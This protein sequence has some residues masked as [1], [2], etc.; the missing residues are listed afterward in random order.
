MKLKTVDYN[1]SSDDEGEE[2]MQNDNPA[3]EESDLG[4]EEEQ[5]EEDEGDMEDGE[6]QPDGEDQESES[7][8]DRH[9]YPTP[10]P[11]DGSKMAALKPMVAKPKA[12]LISLALMA[13]E[14][15]ASRS[16]SSVKAIMSYLK[17]NG[18]EWPDPKKTERLMF[19]ALK[20]AE[21]KEEVI[22]VKRSFK[23]SNKLKSS[24]K[25]VEKMKAKKLKDKEKEKEKKAKAEQLLK[26]KAEKKKAKKK[27]KAM[28]KKEAKEKPS[29]P[30]ERKTKQA[31]KKKKEDGAKDK[32]PASKTA[33]SA[34]VQAMLETPRTT[35][36]GAKI[37]PG[38][39]KVKSNADEE[40]SEAGKAKK[41]RKSIGTLAQ[42]KTARPK[43]KAV[44][45]L[46][47]GKALVLTPDPSSSDM[48]KPQAMS[49][50]QEPTK[51]KRTRKA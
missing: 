44:K 7:E 2:E 36:P 3:S 35:T 31:G 37:K 4:E 28:E 33:A 8:R 32:P 29:K 47:A 12:S 22:M 10:P 13:I 6:E 38:K 5:L 40:A 30:T 43:V 25:A 50:P 48:T 19:R 21:G 39:S 17:E 34:A 23:L 15:L 14:K 24:S 16:G 26:E 41:P 11:D 51:A 49:T 45:K 1:D 42:P 18:H 27:A 20:V 46:V 9:P